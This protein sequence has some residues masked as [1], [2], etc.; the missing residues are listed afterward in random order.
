M[1]SRF[2]NEPF[3]D[4]E[5]QLM[6]T[7]EN[8][9]DVRFPEEEERGQADGKGMPRRGAFRNA[10]Q[11]R[12]SPGSKDQGRP[13][14]GL[15]AVEVSPQLSIA[16]QLV[17][18]RGKKTQRQA[19]DEMGMHIQAYQRLENPDSNLSVRMLERIAGHLGKKL[20]V[21]FV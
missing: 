5:R 10:G 20:E 8:S 3:D 16:L 21:R 14:K 2:I 11:A 18:F 4:E 17:A 15:Y 19:A 9:P 1:E 7:V 6:E 12:P 13:E